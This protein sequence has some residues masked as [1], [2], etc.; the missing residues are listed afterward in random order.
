MTGSR[1]IINNSFPYRYRRTTAENIL[2]KIKIYVLIPRCPVFAGYVRDDSAGTKMVEILLN[3]GFDAIN[4]FNQIKFVG[5][6]E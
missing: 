2:I 4:I 6:S 1:S 3:N 5:N